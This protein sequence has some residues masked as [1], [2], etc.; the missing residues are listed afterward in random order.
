[1]KN[2]ENNIVACE[3]NIKLVFNWERDTVRLIKPML[4]TPV[5]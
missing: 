5:W 2:I 3:E 1:M 4:S